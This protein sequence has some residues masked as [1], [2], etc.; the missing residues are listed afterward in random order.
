MESS[1]YTQ[2][3]QKFLASAGIASRRKAEEYIF[4]GRISVNGEICTEPATKVSENDEV[5]FDG[6]R[7][8]RT[9]KKIYIMLNKPESCVTTAKDQFGRKCAADLITDVEERIYPVGRLDYDTTGLLLLTNDGELTY[10]L[11]HPKHHIEKTY[12]AVL[13]KDIDE[14]S[15]EKLRNGVEIDGRKTYPAKAERLSAAKVKISICE[16]RNRQ[17][18]KMCSAV[19]NEIISLKRISIGKLKLGT[20]KKGECRHLSASEIEYLKYKI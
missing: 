7:V 11:T 18:R 5:L 1:K 12:I 9:E 3:L 16:G 4:Q 19:G 2:R 6:K 20:L 13:K 15:L 10:K 8:F 14:N 17:I